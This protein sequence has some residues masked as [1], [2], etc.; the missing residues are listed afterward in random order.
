M[1]SNISQL[2]IDENIF[3]EI[4]NEI[5]SQEESVLAKKQQS[6][7][8]S[9]ERQR[10]IQEN[11]KKLDDFLMTEEGQTLQNQINSI[12][13]EI[14]NLQISIKN[15]TGSRKESKNVIDQINTEIKSKNLEIDRINNEINNK[16]QISGGRKNT[17]INKRLYINK[18]TKRF[19]KIINKLTK[20]QKKY[21]IHKKTRKSI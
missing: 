6:A 20:R 12:E 2:N 21:K 14:G 10:K 8:T 9:A 15:V 13:E 3:N 11:K 18:F 17:K 16:A 4:Y 5:K 7:V 1:R 19:T